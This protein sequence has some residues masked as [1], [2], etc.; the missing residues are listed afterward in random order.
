[1]LQIIFHVNVSLSYSL[2]YCTS[3]TPS[4]FLSTLQVQQCLPVPRGLQRAVQGVQR[5]AAADQLLVPQRAYQDH[6]LPAPHCPHLPHHPR[7][8]HCQTPQGKEGV[9]GWLVMVFLTLSMFCV[10]WSVYYFI[11]L[12][13]AYVFFFSF[14]YIFAYLLIYSSTFY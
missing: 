6:P 9:R 5:T 14:I 11:G 3:S 10:G 13:A 2:T 4:L 8:V 12:V 7:H 1:M